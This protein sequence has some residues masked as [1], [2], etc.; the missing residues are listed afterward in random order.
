MATREEIFDAIRNADKAGDAEAVRKLGAYLQTM[1]E[2]PKPKGEEPGMLTSVAAGLGKGV[3]QVALNAQ[4]LIGKGAQALGAEGAGQW[5]VNDANTG[6]RKIEGELAPYK[7]ANPVSAG[8][9]E[10]GGQMAATLPAGGL[11]AQGL[12]KVPGIAAMVPNLLQ[13]FRTAGMS[14]GNATGLANPLLRAIGG[15]TT[16]GASAALVDPESAATGAAVGAALPSVVRAAGAVGR[17]IGGAVRPNINNPELARKALDAGIPVGPADVSGN[18]GVRALRSFLNDVPVIGGIGERQGQALQQGFNRA[19][20]RTFGAEAESLTPEVL[21][22]ARKRMGA[23]FDRLWSRNALQ[24]DGDLFGQLQTLRANAGKLPQGEGARLAGWL[25]DIESKMVAGPN[26]ELYMPGEVAN[27]MQ[28]KLREQASK[29]TGFLKEDLQALRG[30]VLGAFKRS[31]SPE[32][33]AALSQN[34]GQYKAFKTVE[35]LLN[36]AEAGVAGRA[37]GDVPAALLPNAVRQSYGSRIAESPFADLSQIGSQYV[38]DRVARTGGGPRAMIQNSAVGTA[39]TAGAFTNPL[40]TLA[41]AGGATGAQKLL[42]S[43]QLTALLLNQS[44]SPNALQAL[45][46]NEQLRQL[47]YRAAPVLVADQ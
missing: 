7:E 17:A 25:D 42:G 33:A 9:G 22:A 34:M 19:V 40:A 30:A 39:L 2:A 46:A 47:G 14:A 4:K 32:D 26:G 35:P 13:S 15:A 38:A 18:R 44:R 20:G 24:F 16:G 45:L 1:Q 10:L 5:L 28:S 43:P 37:A 23:E 31:V 29:A 41:A 6:L 36:S 3:G 11:I 21:D 8:F 27:R 12:S